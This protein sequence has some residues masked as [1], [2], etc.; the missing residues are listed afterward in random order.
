MYVTAKQ[1]S[2][3]NVCYYEVDF[4]AVNHAGTSSLLFATTTAHYESSAGA[5]FVVTVSDA[6]DAV[7]MTWTAPDSN[8]WRVVA[9]I[10]CSEVQ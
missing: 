7:I 10:Y 2:S 6:T 4:A 1:A 8:T 3:G 9:A 5:D